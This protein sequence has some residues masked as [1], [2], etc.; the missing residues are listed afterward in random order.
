MIPKHIKSKNSLQHV[1]LHAYELKLKSIA[2]R[3]WRLLNRLFEG[4]I[5]YN[6]RLI[7]HGPVKIGFARNLILDI[8]VHKMKNS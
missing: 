8:V 1:F 5:V 7:G 4:G 3:F 2:F 6:F